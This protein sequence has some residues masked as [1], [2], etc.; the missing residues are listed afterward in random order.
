M[1]SAYGVLYAVL[2]TAPDR[3]VWVQVPTRRP[4]FISP[5]VTIPPTSDFH[6]PSSRPSLY[7]AVDITAPSTSYSVH[8]PVLRSAANCPVVAGLPLR[9]SVYGPSALP[10][11]YVA[12]TDTFPST[13]F[14]YT[15]SIR[16]RL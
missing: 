14:L 7:V 8:V 5:S 11:L 9:N 3:S 12:C 1:V 10:S 13:Y 4:A 2:R 6:G 16:P 15:P